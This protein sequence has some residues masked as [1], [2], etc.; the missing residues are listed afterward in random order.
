MVGSE[1]GRLPPSF[2]D[3]SKITN[4]IL[5]SGY[6]FDVGRMIYNRYKSVVSY[7]VSEIPLFLAGI[8]PI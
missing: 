4:A 5:T 7:N 6:E 2:I 8:L 1:I 3:A